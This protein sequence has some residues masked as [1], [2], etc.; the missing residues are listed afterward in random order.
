MSSEQDK[1]YWLR[2]H[3]Q[4]E[5]R[6]LEYTL[7]K[8]GQLP[9]GDDW[10]AYYESF[11]VHA[12]NLYVFLTNDEAGNRKA[13]EYVDYQAQKTCRTISVFQ[14]MRA[15]VLHPGKNRSTGTEEKANLG[16]AQAIAKWIGESFSEFAEKLRGKRYFEDL[17]QAYKVEDRITSL[18]QQTT[19]TNQVQTI[20]GSPTE[21]AKRLRVGEWIIVQ[22]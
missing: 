21:I 14:K 1:E 6:M 15:Q 20:S 18:P 19:T 2:E 8:I 9:E 11:A 4:Y 3:L 16:D 22:T 10:N 17:N 7:A 13:K 5:I 12:R